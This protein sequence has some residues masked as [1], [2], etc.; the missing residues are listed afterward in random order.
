MSALSL[1][2]AGK[3]KSTSR[4][5]SGANLVGPAFGLS[6]DGQ[7]GERRLNAI[8]MSAIETLYF[9]NPAITGAVNVLKGQLL[10]NGLSLVRDGKK[11][12][13]KP[14]FKMHLEHVWLPFAS[15]VIDSLLMWGLVVVSYE[16]DEDSLTSQALKQRRIAAEP[17]A[18]NG[19]L[20]QNG[21]T[22]STAP[23]S[24]EETNLFP[25]V[26]P[27]DTCDVA[28]KMGGRAGYLRKYVVYSRAPNQATKIDEG[29]RVIVKNAPD[30][31]GN[32]NS[33][34]AVVFDQGSF[35]SAL[36]ELAIQAETS[37]ARP[38]VWTQTRKQQ[39]NAGAIDTSTLFF[40]AESRNVQAG[41]DE[42]DNF[43]QLGQV[44]ALMKSAHMAN[45]VQPSQNNGGMDINTGSFSGN[46]DASSGRTGNRV[47]YVPSEVPPSVYT[48]P[49]SQEVAPSAGTLAQGRGDLEALT[50]LSIELI[51]AAFGVPSDLIF[52]GRFASKTT[53]QLALLNST[54]SDLARSVSDV[55]TQAYRD[56][57]GDA[58]SEMPA[59]LELITAPLAATEEVVNVYAAGLAPIELAMRSA[60]NAIGA[61]VDEIDAA[62]EAAKIVDEEK[63][64]AEREAEQL[65]LEERK[66]CIAEKKDSMA[67]A[68]KRTGVELE[69]ASANVDKTKAETKAIAAGANEKKDDKSKEK[70]ENKPKQ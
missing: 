30:C 49:T 26:P 46:C 43:G 36:T 35:N 48:L 2:A 50:R 16:E 13:I 41:A 44:H 19:K 42:A 31:A 57:Y 17:G 62:V 64:A 33:P 47:S 10:G 66:A 20:K 7:P 32:V 38:R 27:S 39:N 70:K 68:P 55:L 23:D 65:T 60:L 54:V 56:V 25:I 53:S 37:N 24:S 8:Q 45:R 6:S 15:S 29:A 14:A 58:V 40:D 1:R 28:F 69:Q 22:S 9:T 3:R 11:V 21:A 5:S 59:R 12:D 34:M 67:S 18:K 4:G 52:S 63:K 61:S 51:S